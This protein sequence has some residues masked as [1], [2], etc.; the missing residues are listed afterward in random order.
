MFMLMFS[1]SKLS[2]KT[3]S[4]SSSRTIREGVNEDGLYDWCVSQILALDALEDDYANFHLRFLLDLASAMGF[5]PSAEDLMPFAGEDLERICAL[6]GESFGRAMLLPLTGSE[7]TR[8]AESILRYFSF[9]TESAI[10]LRS[11]A[12]LHACL[13]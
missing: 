3:C 13:A 11:L 12:I 8:I 1:G 7:R 6:A 5:A 9:H 4:P 10:N 2:R